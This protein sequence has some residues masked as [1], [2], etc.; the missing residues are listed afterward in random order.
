MAVGLGFS[1][2]LSPGPLSVLVIGETLK[3]GFGAGLK[4]SI[5]P[6]LTDLPIILISIFIVKQFEN[7]DAVM[8]VISFCGAAVLLKM[9]WESWQSRSV[10]LIDKC[11]LNPVKRGVM[12]NLTSP[13][14]YLFWL[15]V[16]GPL[17]VS[18]WVYKPSLAAIFL[19][20][21][22][23]LLVGLKMA[24]A[25]LAHQSRRFLQKSQYG[26]V[27]RTVGLILFVFSLIL[28][29]RGIRLL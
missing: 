12:V 6:L 8:A 7:T 4:V 21:F 23:F 11:H 27:Q 17:L 29:Y 26:R 24:L 2:G 25:L 10:E 19:L 16:M 1:A 22:Y 9:G 15:T 3:N 18:T 28:I 5:A 20:I 14:P 13:N